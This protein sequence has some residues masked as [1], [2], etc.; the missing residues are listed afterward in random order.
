MYWS[1]SPS[2]F[3][4]TY[5]DVFYIRSGGSLRNMNVSY[6]GAVAPVINLSA[7]YVSTMIG[8]G[9]IGNEYRVE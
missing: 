7:E 1:L 2:A 6:T 9:T 8:D 5:A 3:N 4:G